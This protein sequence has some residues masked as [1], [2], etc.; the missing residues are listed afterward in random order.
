MERDAVAG[1]DDTATPA[2]LAVRIAGLGPDEYVVIGEVAEAAARLWAGSTRVTRLFGE[3]RDHILATRPAMSEHF[4][5]IIETVR[6]PDE[7]H[8]YPGNPRSATLWRLVDPTHYVQ[9]AVYISEDAALTNT[10]ITA[11]YTRAK[12]I[13]KRRNQGLEVWRRP[14]GEEHGSG[15]T[16]GP[17]ISFARWLA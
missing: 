10:V 14:G 4:A 11:I 5:D 9:V 12:E 1:G 7:I 15:G 8:R 6:D 16:A 2:S 3:R 13:V 17:H